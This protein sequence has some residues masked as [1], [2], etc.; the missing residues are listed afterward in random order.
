MKTIKSEKKLCLICMEEHEVDIVE[1]VEQEI[2][3]GEELSFNSIYEYCA[4]A[5]ELLET[6]EMI[7]KNS[8]AMKD[9]YRKKVGLLTSA[10][11]INIREKYGVSQ[12]DFSEILD[13]GRA[14]ITR[15]E[16]HQVQDRAHDDVL[17]K[18]DSDPKWFLEMLTRAKERLSSKTYS[19][20]KHEASEQFKKKR[21]QYLVNSIQATY[22]DYEDEIIT[23]RVCLNL[24]KVVEMINYLASKVESLHKVKLMKML[25]YSDNLHFKRNGMAISGL[26]YIALPNGA[27]P[28]GY[29]QIVLLNGVSFDTVYYGENI[30]YKFKPTPGLELNELRQSE[31]QVLDDVILKFGNY[32]T[33]EIVERMHNEVAYKCTEIYCII[34][35]TFAEQL[36][37]D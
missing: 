36:T 11:I 21:N 26:A 12:K 25:W 35:F 22:A 5:D 34:P 2:F 6:E 14:T 28:E 16:N 8:L 30:A 31:I 23:G 10:D 1:I 19:K 18:I 7:K 27:V 3:K 13:W 33:D 17:R 20:Y 29:D 37:I 4:N 15:Y 24:N 9:A 32:N